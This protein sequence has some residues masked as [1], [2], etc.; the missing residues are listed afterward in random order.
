V[1]SL[2]K[3]YHL[4]DLML[5]LAKAPTSLPLFI[6]V[7]LLHSLRVP[8]LESDFNDCIM[9]FAE[10]PDLEM[11]KLVTHATEMMRVT[12]KSVMAPIDAISAALSVPGMI[13]GGES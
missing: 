3:V 5:P 7:A 11:S 4:F 8:L 10:L 2:Y 1:F 12:P 6:G 9:W 13:D